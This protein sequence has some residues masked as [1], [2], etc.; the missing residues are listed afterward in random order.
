MRVALFLVLP[1]PDVVED[2]LECEVG[3]LALGRLLDQVAIL[4]PA[5]LRDKVSAA[6]D[7][8][9]VDCSKDQLVSL[10]ID[11][12][13]LP[14][15]GG[16]LRVVRSGRA[17]LRHAAL[18][19]DLGVLARPDALHVPKVLHEHLRAVGELLTVSGV[20]AHRAVV[21]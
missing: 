8:C 12:V 2:C 14:E 3:H 13:R 6:A 9:R 20:H 16:D 18:V 19:D 15:R 5:S 10:C 17:R 11:E 1:R 4:F 21:P 7:R